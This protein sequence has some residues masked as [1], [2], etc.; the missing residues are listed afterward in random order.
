MVCGGRD[1][2]D[3]DAIRERLKLLQAEYPD[4][5]II[6]GASPGTDTWAGYAA[7]SLG[8][9][10]EVHPANWAKYG[11]T[12][13]PTRNQEMLDSGI[14]LVIF[15]P[16]EHGIQDMTSRVERSNVPVERITLRTGVPSLSGS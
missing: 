12:A 6:H 4:A 7:E 2:A 16:G 3:V 9:A 15:F 1:Y 14:D 5:V 13:I 10:V 11:K 8:L